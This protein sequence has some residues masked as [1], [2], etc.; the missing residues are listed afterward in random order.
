MIARFFSN[1]PFR[2]SLIA[3]GFCFSLFISISRFFEP[4]ELQ[5]YD[6]RCQLRGTRPV[7]R[8]IV[9]IDIWDDTLKNIGAWP[10]ERVY[11]A[12]LIK[13]LS[14]YGVKAIGLD[15]LFVEPRQGDDKVAE[16]AKEAGN[17]Y[18]AEA[19]LN[20]EKRKG[21]FVAHQILA[22]L[23]EDYRK[24]AKGVGQVNVMADRD[25]KRRRVYPV[26]FHEDKPVYQLS[27]KIAMDVLGIDEKQVRLEPGK[28]IEFSKDL[29]IPLDDEG[30]FIVNFAGKWEKTYRH[31]SYYDVLAA[32]IEE[33]QGKKPRIDLR[34]LKGKICVIGL[35]S[36]GSHD[37][38]PV[39]IQSIYPMV[40]MY[41][42]VLNGILNK[43]FI[44][45]ADR[46]QNGILL[47]LAGL[48]V[49][50]MAVRLKPSVALLGTLF[51]LAAFLAAVVYLF[52]KWGVWVDLFY[53]IIFM[54][55][56]YAAATLLRMMAEVRKR[57][58]ME[59]ELKIA[60]DIQKSFLPATLPK[61]PG[62]DVAVF[63]KPAKEV[64]GDL[65]TFLKVG[66]GQL[67]V[68][69]GDVS[70]KGTPAALFMA[71]V[72][73]EFKFCAHE[74]TDPAEVLSSLNRLIAS[75][76]TGGLF[77]TVGYVIFNARTKSLRL[78]SG[79]HLP[80]SWVSQK[81]DSGFIEPDQGMPV[82]LVE[83]SEFSNRERELS[84]GDC[85][86]LY[87]DGVS[88][89]R[90]RRKEEFG[91]QVLQKILLEHRQL[92]AAG[93]LEKVVERIHQFVDKAEQHDDM[94][95]IIVKTGV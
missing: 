78:A 71:K 91:T 77:V 14:A 27:F 54:V 95:L 17:V 94:T 21:Y 37:T 33:A 49:I 66:E 34:E 73:S 68:M 36:L 56:C 48:M 12:D 61:E 5:T 59:N 83:T 35:T 29:R 8:D 57:E 62:F 2:Y 81:G 46:L 26:V 92:S 58:V 60:S 38:S 85:F 19:F 6:W 53:P 79:G 16:A 20:P 52:L 15:I 75:E 45:R 39:P 25:G 89:A 63:M 23:I 82:G 93:L 43:D 31:Y 64:G 47:I 86:A 3:L 30:F 90:N 51:F 84:R 50:W 87:S 80:M 10:F 1:K 13:I 76:G 41:A 4:Y 40:G 70:G 67:G 22:P 32:A 44:R 74:K 42:N 18:F 65:Y 7:S 24:V 55:I 72:V 9:F 11:H 88:E 28:M 69:V